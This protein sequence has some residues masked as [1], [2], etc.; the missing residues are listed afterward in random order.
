MHKIH[1]DEVVVK[2]RVRWFGAALVPLAIVIALTACTPPAPA[3]ASVPVETA[4][5]PPTSA[6]PVTAAAGALDPTGT[7][8]DNLAFFNAVNQALIAS[9]PGA[10]G[11]DF[12]SNLRSQGFDISAMQ[13]TPDITTVGVKADSIQFSVHWGSDCLIGQYGQ[14]HYEGIVAPALGNGACLIGQTRTI[15]W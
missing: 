4:T 5:V 8:S 9:N 15:D 12:T 11:Q 1:R 13:V 7:A 6:A 14:G 3:P 2:P 10:G